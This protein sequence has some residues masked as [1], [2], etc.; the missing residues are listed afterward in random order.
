[1]FSGDPWQIKARL[2][3]VKFIAESSIATSGFNYGPLVF[4]TKAGINSVVLNVVHRGCRELFEFV[5]HMF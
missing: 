3:E 4:L 5:L 2:G 1:M